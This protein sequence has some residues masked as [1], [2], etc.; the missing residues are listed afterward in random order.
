MQKLEQGWPDCLR[1]PGQ[2]RRDVSEPTFHVLPCRD[3]LGTHIVARQ[4]QEAH[5]T[6]QDDGKHVSA[7]TSYAATDIM[8]RRETDT[9]YI[10]EL[11]ID[12]HE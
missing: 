7:V 12:A 8:S 4:R 2:Q 9:L 10:Y 6:V 3:I 1:Q 11:R 5:R